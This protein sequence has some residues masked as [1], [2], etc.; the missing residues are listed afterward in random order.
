MGGCGCGTC[1]PCLAQGGGRAKLAQRLAPVADRLRGR[2]ARAGLRPYRVFLVWVQ[3]DG[4]ERG[5]G[6]PRVLREVEVLP[7][8]KVED[9]TAVSLSAFSGGI[10]PV[11]SI[12]ISEVTTA[13]TADNLAGNVVP[14]Q[15]YLDGCGSPRYAGPQAPP[16]LLGASEADLIGHALPKA[17]ESIPEP[18]EFF[19]EVVED[20]P[21]AQR[22]RYR[23]FAQPFR[24]AGKF[25]WSVTLTRASED[26]TRRGAVRVPED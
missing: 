8:P 16:A 7:V 14:P 25:D 20:A 13:L 3:W 10:L 26:R 12:R 18:Y 17:G 19:W 15:A 5:A 22:Q 23:L 11:G 6:H 9:L 1:G 21:G 2:L 24:R 4:E